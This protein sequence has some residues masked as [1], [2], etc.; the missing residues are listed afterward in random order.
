M[1]A[2]KG[3]L[4][5]LESKKLFHNIISYLFNSPQKKFLIMKVY[6]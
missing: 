6:A 3:Q 4:E 5:I 2:A 1:H